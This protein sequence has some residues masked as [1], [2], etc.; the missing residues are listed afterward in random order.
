MGISQT[1]TIKDGMSPAF[2]AMT[3]SIGACVGAFSQLQAATGASVNTEKI[4]GCTTAMYQ[5]LFYSLLGI[6]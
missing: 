6:R 4:T 3:K 1:V 2:G 5:H